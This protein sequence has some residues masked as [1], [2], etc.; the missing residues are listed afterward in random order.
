MSPEKVAAGKEVFEQACNSCHGKGHVEAVNARREFLDR[1]TPDL[2]ALDK[3]SAR[4]AGLEGSL[5]AYDQSIESTG[6][7]LA[8]AVA[9]RDAEAAAKEREAKAVETESHVRIIA[10]A[11]AKIDVPLASLIG[12]LRAASEPEATQAAILLEDVRGQIDRAI[13]AIAEILKSRAA[14]E[15]VP[16]AVVPSAPKITPQPE[17]RP[18]PWRRGE[19]VEPRRV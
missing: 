8:N 13:P 7:A 11:H 5:T 3:L 19:L 12:A 14:R 1:G 15:R 18:Q 17:L 2:A 4:I 6:V 9:R 16:P 10:D